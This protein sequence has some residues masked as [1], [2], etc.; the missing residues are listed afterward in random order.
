MWINLMLDDEAT[1]EMIQ[2]GAAD[3]N[4]SFHKK[5]I[6]IAVQSPSLVGLTTLLGIYTKKE[7]RFL[8]S[9]LPITS[10]NGNY[11]M[12]QAL[13]NA[14]A[15][16]NYTD[17]QY[18]SPLLLASADNHHKVI[19]ALLKAGADVRKNLGSDWRQTYASL[20]KYDQQTISMLEH[21]ELELDTPLIKKQKRR[22]NRL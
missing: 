13:L 1:P 19:E 21:A 20:S 2:R 7:E 22:S 16:P 4:K 17:P 10:K 12:T 8:S 11:E 9:L 5:A 15:S 3:L 6:A 18:G 14:G